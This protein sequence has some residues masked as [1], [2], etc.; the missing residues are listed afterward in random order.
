MRPPRLN[1]ILHNDWVTMRRNF[2][3]SFLVFSTL[4][5]FVHPVAAQEASSSNALAELSADAV[6]PSDRVLDVQI[7]VAEDDWN[8]IRKQ[9]RN[10]FE[11]LSE[12]RQYGP[13]PGP[14]T[15]VD[16][17]VTIDGHDLGKIGL[18]KKGFIGSQSEDRPSLK[19]KLNR[20]NA[21]ANIDGMTNLTFNNNHQDVSQVDQFMGYQLFRKAGCPAPK[22]AFA[23]VTVNGTSLGVYTHV[24]TMRQA[25][26]KREFGS[27]TGTLFEG[28]VVDFVDDW[29]AAFEHKFGDE[30]AGRQYIVELTR[31][32]P[33]DQLDGDWEKVIDEFVD[34]DSFYRYWAVE[35][36]LGFWDGYCANSNNFY[37][38]LNPNDGKFHFL[39]WGLD[40]AFDKKS[41]IE[42]DENAPMSVK[43]KG[44]LA[45]KL[46]QSKSGR[47]R[48]AD[49][50]VT[51]MKEHWDEDALIA[52]SKRIEKMI[53][54][55]LHDAQSMDDEIA[56]TRDF[57]RQRKS[58]VLEE[59]EGG[60]PDYE[61]I[62]DPP[63][64][65]PKGM[66]KGMVLLDAAYRDKFGVVE[67]HIESGGDVDELGQGGTTPLMMAALG[68]RIKMA[69]LLLDSGADINK[70]KMDGSTALHTAAFMAHPEMVKFLLEK[71][72]DATIRNGRNETAY[73]SA[74]APWSPMLEGI[75]KFIGGMLKEE[76]DLERIKNSRPKVAE[77]LKDAE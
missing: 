43:C 66:K 34:L 73:D 51:L 48:I 41:K 42:F 65:M 75:Y 72:A 74:A 16:A 52:E 59:I 18:R 53:Q 39:P 23:H 40:A 45:H 67:K 1:S 29:E 47:K 70:K 14:Y 76:L 6:F 20:H 64:V 26:C 2:F 8:T 61:K 62:P 57:I 7:T 63:F 5:A 3:A 58:D 49:E 77:I 50:I 44:M 55:H 31:A 9:S 27:D 46:Y 37:V 15:Y 24:E 56:K 11:A 22:C 10:F 17:T 4:L 68:G 19:V 30:A 71:G 21:E 13:I 60:L 33:R 12:K 69:Q 32:M 38:Y 25:F 35:N 54:P 28:T 36:L